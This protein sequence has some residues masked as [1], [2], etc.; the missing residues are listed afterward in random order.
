MRAFVSVSV[1]TRK[2]SRN[3]KQRKWVGTAWAAGGLV[4]GASSALLSTPGCVCVLVRSQHSRQARGQLLLPP[5]HSAGS[6]PD[7]GCISQDPGESSGEGA[8]R[9]S[10]FWV[11]L[12]CQFPQRLLG[13]PETLTAGR[14][15]QPGW[16]QPLAGRP[17]GVA[18]VRSRS[19]LGSA[20]HQESLHVC[21][22]QP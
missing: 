6:T 9:N 12:A 20:K 15:V 1:R 10:C 21:L 13:H 19:R 17:A 14:E 7:T 22:T 4:I 3:N 18:A 8:P 2:D 11:S 5:F 16:A